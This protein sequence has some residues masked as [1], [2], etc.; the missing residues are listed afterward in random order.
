MVV[1]VVVVVM[2]VIWRGCNRGDVL[3]S[4]ASLGLGGRPTVTGRH[5]CCCGTQNMVNA[6]SVLAFTPMMPT[7]ILLLIGTTTCYIC[8]LLLQIHVC[9]YN[10]IGMNNGNCEWNGQLTTCR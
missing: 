3:T 2:V 9:V 5:A 1:S 10:A 8:L 6:V 4:F 7:C